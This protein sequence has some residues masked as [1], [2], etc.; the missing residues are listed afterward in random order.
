V[1]GAAAVSPERL[2]GILL[3]LE[4]IRRCVVRHI[5]GQELEG[6]SSLQLS[7]WRPGWLGFLPVGRRI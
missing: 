7:G 2:S 5:V 6:L 1:S 4:L 3:V